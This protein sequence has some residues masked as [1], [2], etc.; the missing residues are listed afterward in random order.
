MSEDTGT[1]TSRGWTPKNRYHLQRNSDPRL[2]SNNKIISA[3]EAPRPVPAHPGA[4]RLWI[5][6]HVSLVLRRQ[7][8]RQFYGSPL[9]LPPAAAMASQTVFHPDRI[10]ALSEDSWIGSQASYVPS[11]AEGPLPLPCS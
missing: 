2:L 11:V 4:R 1:P 3:Q 7:F 10:P 5:K 9:D 6:H 8:S